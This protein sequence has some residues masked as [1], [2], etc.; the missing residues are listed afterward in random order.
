[1]TMSVC[2]SASIFLELQFR[3]SPNFWRMLPVAMARLPPAALRYVMYF[4][5][6]DDV[7]FAH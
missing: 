6:L 5:F 4:R 1:M 7:V 3:S 2:L